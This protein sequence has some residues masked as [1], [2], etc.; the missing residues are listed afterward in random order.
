MGR[1][2]LRGIS[3]CLV[4]TDPRGGKA[5]A[6]EKK[7]PMRGKREGCGGQ[8]GPFYAMLEIVAALRDL[9]WHVLVCGV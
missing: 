5:E 8:R 1:S 2:I 4:P 3:L 6:Q 7:P 9:F